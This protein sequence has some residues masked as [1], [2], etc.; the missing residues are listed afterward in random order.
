MDIR[1]PTEND[2]LFLVEGASLAR[3]PIW[4][5]EI[6]FAAAGFKSAA[7]DM[8]EALCQ[9]HTDNF[10]IFPIVYCYRHY[11]EL[12]LKHLIELFNRFEETG[13]EFPRTHDLMELWQMVRNNCYEPEDLVSVDEI[14]HVERLIG[15]FHEFDSRSTAFRYAERVSLSEIDLG[16]LSDV[17]EGLSNHLEGLADVWSNA[18]DSKF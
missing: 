9:G 5:G 16:N 3:L 11:L 14:P 13:E 7:D 12:T 18:I 10:W 6:S 8:V 2:K 4:H 1:W 17:M 15:E